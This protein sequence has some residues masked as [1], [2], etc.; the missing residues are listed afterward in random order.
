MALEILLRDGFNPLADQDREGWDG[1]RFNELM[2]FCY[3]YKETDVDDHIHCEEAYARIAAGY[4][5]GIALGMR[6]SGRLGGVR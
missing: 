3:S 5:V 2:P 1:A 6:L 4:M